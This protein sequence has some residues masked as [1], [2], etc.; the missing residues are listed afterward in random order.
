MALSNI[1]E[2]LA[3]LYDIEASM[4]MERGKDLFR[5]TLEFPC[6]EHGRRENA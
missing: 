5:L 2:R 1:R 4:H 6:R 3:L